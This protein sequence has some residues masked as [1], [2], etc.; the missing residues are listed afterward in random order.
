VMQI[1]RKFITVPLL[2]SARFQCVHRHKKTK[3]AGDTQGS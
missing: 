3:V 1:K 2:Y